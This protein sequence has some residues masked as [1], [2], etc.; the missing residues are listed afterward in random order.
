VTN[1]G[2]T[3]AP[4]DF[5]YPPAPLAA[6][7]LATIDPD[8]GPAGGGTAVTITGT[9]FEAGST[10]SVDGSAPITPTVIAADG[11]SLTYTAPAH[12]AGTVPVTVTNAGGTS[13]PLD[14]TYLPAPLRRRPC[15]RRSTLPRDRLAAAPSSP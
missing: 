13:A 8:E 1:A 2:G 9:G 4:L 14:F 10:V 11:T 6:P 7:V 12:V 5:T 3:S 15:S